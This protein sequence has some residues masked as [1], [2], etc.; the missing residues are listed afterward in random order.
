M[1]KDIPRG[2]DCRVVEVREPASNVRVVGDEDDSPRLELLAPA[3]GALTCHR[4]AVLNLL[5]D[6]FAMDRCQ[7]QPTG[8]RYAV[9]L[10]E[11]EVL[12]PFVDMREDAVVEEL[13]TAAKT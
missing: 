3:V 12:H 4:C 8:L 1:L 9:E 6:D 2:V 11:P 13:E 5:E 7:H 10:G